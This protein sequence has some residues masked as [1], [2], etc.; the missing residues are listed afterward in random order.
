MIHVNI[1]ANQNAQSLASQAIAVLLLPYGSFPLEIP[2]VTTELQNSTSTFPLDFKQP[3][4]L[5]L[6]TYPI[7]LQVLRSI[8]RSLK[9]SCEQQKEKRKSTAEARPKSSFKILTMEKEVT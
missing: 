9:L 7:F 6:D 1:W 5:R 8:R 4:L 2:G 3:K